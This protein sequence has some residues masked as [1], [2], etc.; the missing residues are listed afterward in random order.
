MNHF[1]KIGASLLVLLG[2]IILVFLMFQGFGDPARMLA[3]QTGNEQTIL[4]IR[5]DLNLDKPKWKQFLYYLNDVSPVAIHSKNEIKE[6]D[7][8]GIFLPVERSVGLKVPY[9]GRSYQSRRPVTTVLM[10][11]LPGTLVLAFTAM[12][13]ACVAGITLGVIAALKKGTW[14]DSGILVSSIAGISAPSFF[15]AILIA[16]IFGIVLHDI[17]GLNFTGSLFSVN[18]ST[19]EYQMELK[20]LVLPAIT[21]V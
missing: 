13:I 8:K 6:K 5:K 19:G 9:L 2:V 12:L 7:L 4:N 15:M 1:R 17:T 10:E 3:G 18:A 16:Y 20:N 14:M 21:L 11:A